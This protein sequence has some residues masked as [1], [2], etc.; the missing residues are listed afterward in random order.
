MIHHSRLLSTVLTDAVLQVQG[1]NKTQTIRYYTQYDEYTRHG[2]ET[3]RNEARLCVHFTCRIYLGHWANH[4]ARSPPGDPP[5]RAV[6][7]ALVTC[8]LDPVTILLERDL[9]KYWSCKREFILFF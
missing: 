6:I 5:G 3:A 4:R 7:L 8:R 1:C 9:A 2:Q